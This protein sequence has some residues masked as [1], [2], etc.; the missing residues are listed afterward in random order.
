[1]WWTETQREFSEFNWGF[2]VARATEE[3]VREVCPGWEAPEGF[4]R[5]SPYMPV[6][7]GVNGNGKA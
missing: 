6:K 3:L 4:W 2:D 7:Q 5:A 1:M